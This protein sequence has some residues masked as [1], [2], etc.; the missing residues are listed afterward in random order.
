MC[1]QKVRLRAE[2][3]G[4]NMQTLN[5]CLDAQASSLQ[6]CFQT[7]DFDVAAYLVARA[8]PLL[9]TDQMQESPVFT[10]SAEA[11]LGAEAFYSGATI[12][13]KLLLH[14]AR[15]LQNMRENEQYFA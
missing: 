13:A 8:Y 6:S 9:R 15:R 1:N 3:F 4:E 10:F 7:T 2:L 14:A 11:G 5:S 12:S